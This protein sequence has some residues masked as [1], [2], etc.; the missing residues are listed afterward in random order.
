[1][2]YRSTHQAPEVWKVENGLRSQ[3]ELARMESIALQMPEDFEGLKMK[4]SDPDHHVRSMAASQ[5]A[6]P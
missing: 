6:K 4:M 1:M 3:D 5:D 2:R